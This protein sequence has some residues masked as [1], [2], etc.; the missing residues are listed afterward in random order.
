MTIKNTYNPAEEL[1]IML[2][3]DSFALDRFKIDMAKAKTANK[4]TLAKK[5]LQLKGFSLD[6]LCSIHPFKRSK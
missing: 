2:R 6:E 4:R 1:T 3:L 5:K